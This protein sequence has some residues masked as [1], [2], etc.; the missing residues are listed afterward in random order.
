MLSSGAFPRDRMNHANGIDAMRI[1][2]QSLSEPEGLREF[3]LRYGKDL[4]ATTVVRAPHIATDPRAGQAPT[5]S[6]ESTLF[7]RL[8]S[9][10]H[11]PTVIAE[12]GRQIN[13][14]S[15]APRISAYVRSMLA[16][17]LLLREDAETWR[18]VAVC[19]AKD[20]P[21]PRDPAIAAPLQA[22]RYL[23]DQAIADGAELLHG[24]HAQMY[25][26]H[27]ALDASR[28]G[29][30][31][32]LKLERNILELLN[33][34]NAVVTGALAAVEIQATRIG[35]EDDPTDLLL[36]TDALRKGIADFRV[37]VATASE[38]IRNGDIWR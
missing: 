19:R 17:V 18:A 25:A 31:P 2:P 34:F 5:V 27:D 32:P 4:R 29:A 33:T 6:T 15:D 35:L 11:A 14:Q 9:G 3:A 38:R 13:I 22:M 16:S 30:L 36:A 37:N 23:G 24:L 8:L 26:A 12:H 28:R 20:I 10:E 7:V 21:A 1:T